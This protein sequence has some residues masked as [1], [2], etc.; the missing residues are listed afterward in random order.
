MEENKK[1]EYWI[2]LAEDECFS[3]YSIIP[4]DVYPSFHR[5]SRGHY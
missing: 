2:C 5:F 4:K 1:N 3:Q